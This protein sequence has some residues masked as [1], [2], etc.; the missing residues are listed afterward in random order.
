MYLD[1]TSHALVNCLLLSYTKTLQEVPDI[2]YISAYYVIIKCQTVN[3]MAGSMCSKFV[4]VLVHTF[5]YSVKF[6]T[7][8]KMKSKVVLRNVA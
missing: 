7:P 8:Q 1:F 3:D 6:C 2:K 4:V 5:L